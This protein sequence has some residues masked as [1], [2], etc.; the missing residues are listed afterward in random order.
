M[1]NTRMGADDSYYGH[2]RMKLLDLVEGSPKRILDIGC[3][4]GQALSYLKRHCS[5]EFVVGVELVPEVAKIARQNPEVDFVFTGDFEHTQL[6]FPSG[7]FDLIMASHVLEHFKDPWSVARRLRGL[8]SPD[9]QFI[10]AL[11]NIRHIKISLPLLVT[12]KFQYVDDGILDWTHT[13][14]FAKST[15]RDF[16][17]SSG[18][19]VQKIE[20]EFM[21]RAA[22]IDKMTLGLFKNLFCFAYNFS[23]RASLTADSSNE[24]VSIGVH[25]PRAHESSAA[26]N[27]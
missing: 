27:P 1:K 14:F 24:G 7:Y 13:K 18:F 3:G 22:L 6:N 15:I 5:A 26:R 25:P 2:L 17:S 12:G 4:H 20:P 8:L 21:V 23:A 11:P 19:I 16:L 9:G 10:G